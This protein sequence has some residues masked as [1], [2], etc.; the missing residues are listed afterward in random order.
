MNRRNDPF[1]RRDFLK[2]T[3]RASAALIAA[4]YVITSGALGSDERPAASDR[5][6]VGFIGL[7]GHGIGRN[8]QMFLNQ[9]DAEPV[10][11]CDVDAGRI[12]VGLATVRKRRGESFTCPTTT[13]WR[14]VIARNDV[15]AVMISTA[16][17]W[18]VPMSVAAIRA[19]KDVICE[20]PTL[21]IAQGRILADTVK[22]YGAVFQTSTEDRSLPIY[23]RMAELVRNG[24][25]GTLQKVYCQLPAGPDNAG[26]P[27]PKPVPEGFDWEMWLGPAPWYPYREGLHMFHWRWNRDYSGGQLTDWG[28]HQL[29]TVQLANDTERTGPVEVEGKGKRH[30]NGLYDTFHEYHLTYRYANGVELHV[31]SG[32]TGLR[33]EGSDGWIGNDGWTAPLKA[34][35]DEILQSVIGPEEVHLFTCP[36]G[37]H[38]NFLD[39]VKSRR[40]PYFPAE[41][42]HRCS[43]VSHIGNIAM[44]LGRK[45]RW[46]PGKE[47]FSDDETANR[48]RSRAQREPWGSLLG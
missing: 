40:D 30:E 5:I 28:A 26:D 14:E 47:E 37:E 10:A 9:Q 23:H 29:D 15:D 36:Q 32:G 27:K 44:E 18:H 45:L 3:T 35:S 11:L 6:S 17:H 48:M 43:T 25:I 12:D 13:D 7:G 21:T 33:F 46:D 1:D 19:G 39:C 22:R 42:G 38:R 8:L 4:P 34:S 41:V 16:D 2:R 31:D 24:R 20:K